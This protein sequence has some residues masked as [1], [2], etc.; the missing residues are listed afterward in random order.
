[1][2]LVCTWVYRKGLGTYCKNY[3][4]VFYYDTQTNNFSLWLNSGAEYQR[5]NLGNWHLAIKKRSARKENCHSQAWNNNTKKYSVQIFFQNWKNTSTIIQVNHISNHYGKCFENRDKIGFF[6]DQKN[7][8]D[9]FL[10][11]LCSGSKLTE[12]ERKGDR[13]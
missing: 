10:P 6:S 4:H 9:L 13:I 2:Y 7:F 3:I 12:R 5:L 1:M 11:F 8:Q